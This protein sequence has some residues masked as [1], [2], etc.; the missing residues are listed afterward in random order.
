VLYLPTVPSRI[1]SFDCIPEK[2]PVNEIDQ[3]A[4]LDA[5]AV[6]N[7]KFYFNLSPLNTRTDAK[8]IGI[9]FLSTNANRNPI[10]NKYPLG[11]YFAPVQ[12]DEGGLYFEIPSGLFIRTTNSTTSGSFVIDSNR[13]VKRIKGSTTSTVLY[14][15]LLDASGINEFYRSQIKILDGTVSIVSNSWVFAR[16]GTSSITVTAETL[17]PISNEYISD[18]SEPTLLKPIFIGD[19]ESSSFGIAGFTSR[20]ITGELFV[21]NLVNSEFFNFQFRYFDTDES[22]QFFQF[23][24]YESNKEL[25]ED[26][27][28]L[29][30]DRFSGAQYVELAAPKSL[31]WTNTKSLSNAEDYFITLTF[32]TITGFFYTYQYSFLS[33]YSIA[34]LGL[35]FKA[36]NDEDNGR[37]EFEIF[38]RQV[39]FVNNNGISGYQ[40][41]NSDDLVTGPDDVKENALEVSTALMTN[42]QALIFNTNYNGW[43][44]QGIFAKIQPKTNGPLD[45]STLEQDFMFK[46]ED[47]AENSQFAYY[48]IPVRYQ[49][50]KDTTYTRIDWQDRVL[51]EFNL[52]KVVKNFDEGPPSQQLFLNDGFNRTTASETR[53]EIMNTYRAYMTPNNST[54]GFYASINGTSDNPAYSS[55]ED[56]SN[57]YFIFL[58][59]SNGALF[60]YAKHLNPDSSLILERAGSVST[61]SAEITQID[62]TSLYRGMSVEGKGIPIDTFIVSIGTDSVI[63]S[64]D[65]LSEE[66]GET[67]SFFSNVDRLNSQ[68]V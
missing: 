9:R 53:A 46:L 2:R 30:V 7:L 16:T 35:G 31:L 3:F 52:V 22:L 66:S 34:P 24:I 39:N 8:F 54:A 11:V 44:L 62:T 51:N 61:S 42:K 17:N 28:P 47:A 41:V 1:D 67:Y 36:S 26:S 63:I 64:D 27:G 56:D 29:E 6:N 4:P 18:W 19:L 5:L 65:P 59:E 57:K 25:Y 55:P 13:I 43:S 38:G 60:L 12:Q 37:I 50:P 21:D 20:E 40:F 15:D 32:K 10:V 68:G 49:Q 58:G 33:S 23:K 45:Y 48:L 14:S